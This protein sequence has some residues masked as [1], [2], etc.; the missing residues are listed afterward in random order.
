MEEAVQAKI[1]QCEKVIMLSDG[2]S[3]IRAEGIYNIIITTPK[4]V[5]YKFF[6]VK[7]KQMTGENI[8][9]MFSEVIKDIGEDKVAAVV[10][11]SCS[12]MIK[13]HKILSE[14]IPNIVCYRCTAHCLHLL[15]KDILALKTL[16]NHTART[17]EL[18]K[19]F[20]YKHVPAATLRRI[21][22]QTGEGMSL[23]LMS[24]TRWGSSAAML[25]SVQS[26]KKNLRLALIEENVKSALEKDPQVEKSVNDSVFW[27]Q[28]E[29][30]TWLLSKISEAILMIE[31]DEVPLSRYIHVYK[32][33]Q[34]EILDHVRSLPFQLSEENEVKKNVRK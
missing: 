24:P 8:A 12:S 27:S 6:E 4:P 32:C 26:N 33:M 23:Q 25:K 31:G 3:N 11:D 30:F 17:K 28:N 29:K 13:A 14:K 10:T 22:K 7:E 2:W 34:N 20:K 1:N 19:A 9:Q 15:C 16:S 18:V 21:Q 5:F